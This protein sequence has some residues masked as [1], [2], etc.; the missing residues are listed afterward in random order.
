MPE[1]WCYLKYRGRNPKVFIGWQQT[2]AVHTTYKFI[3]GTSGDFSSYAF[4]F[5]SCFDWVGRRMCGSLENWRIYKITMEKQGK[6]L[7]LLGKYSVSSSITHWDVNAVLLAFLHSLGM[8]KLTPAIG[9]VL[10][11]CSRKTRQWDSDCLLES[12][13]FNCLTTVCIPLGTNKT[14]QSK[15]NMC[16]PGTLSS[17]WVWLG[18]C[19]FLAQPLLPYCFLT[20]INSSYH[21]PWG[22]W[23]IMSSVFL[24]PSSFPTLCYAMLFCE[25]YLNSIY[26]LPLLYLPTFSEGCYCVLAKE[27]NL[28]MS[29]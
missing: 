17:L 28:T 4:C 15:T 14:K 1:T 10:W 24:W 5:I 13:S 12:Y 11:E 16:M 8:K 18:S 26:V 29:S 22:F 9:A 25:E 7:R 27:T 21:C 20:I 2:S 19:L 23:F 3:R 6:T